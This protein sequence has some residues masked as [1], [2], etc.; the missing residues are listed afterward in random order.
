MNISIFINIIYISFYFIP[1]STWLTLPAPGRSCPSVFLFDRLKSGTIDDPVQLIDRNLPVIVSDDRFPFLKAD[2]RVDDTRC[3]FES[4]L[5]RAGT[6]ASS[7]SGDPDCYRF[8]G[9]GSCQ[10]SNGKN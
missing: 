7:H 1:A 10:N 4:L 5:D 6:P 2:A 8:D 9:G 3:L